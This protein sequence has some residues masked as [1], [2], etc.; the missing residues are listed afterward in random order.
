MDPLHER[1]LERVTRLRRRPDVRFRLGEQVECPHQ[2]FA[3][4]P[5]G[6][7]GQP[8][9]LAFGGDLRILHP[10]GVDAHDHEVAHQAR[11]LPADQ[12]EIETRVHDRARQIERPGR[13]LGATV[14]AMSNCTSRPIRPS[15]VLT[16]SA[17]ISSL[18]N[19]ST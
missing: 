19:A 17:V 14:S 13:V 6:E 15:T 12:P 4:E 11:Q 2:V 9:A 3:R 7:R 10:R 1:H 16:L 18:V 8:I 5:L